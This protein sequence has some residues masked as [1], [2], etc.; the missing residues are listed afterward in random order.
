MSK[1]EPLDTVWPLVPLKEVT[2]DVPSESP[3]DNGKP[4][5]TYV[6]ISA[7]NNIRCEIDRPKRVVSAAAP[8]R[9]RRPIQDDDVLF[10]NVRTYLRNVAQVGGL[11]A[12]TFA[13]TGFT[14]LRP[15]PSIVSR[16]LYHVVRSD[17][18]IT[19]V[20]PQQTG[21]HYP[22]T[23][24]R[25]VRSQL[26]PLPD[27]DTQQR[28]ARVLDR[29]EQLRQSAARHVACGREA[30][31]RLR[32]AVLAAACSGQLTQ[33][34]RRENPGGERAEALIARIDQRRQDRLGN[35]YKPPTH[36]AGDRTLPNG[37]TWTTVAAVGDVATGATPLRAR[38]DYYG[39][40]VPWVT[41]SAVNAGLIMDARERITD[42]ALTETSAKVF[43]AGTLLVAMYGEGQT[44]G[45][46][47]ELGISAATNQAVAAI[48]FDEV[49]ESVQ[50]FLK[51]FLL[52]NYERIRQLSFGGVQ[53]NLSLG[54]IKSM[55]VAL[56]PADER[57]EIVRC[58]RACLNAATRLEQRLDDAEQRIDQ[59]S[60]ALLSSA[61]RGGLIDS[62]L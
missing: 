55:V 27:L 43:P 28:L 42:L 18:F 61:L 35:R 5:F 16:Y 9:A 29:T 13:S 45:R 1:S 36:P 51:V 8:S 2:I 30:S 3:A 37:W 14:V 59:T 52:A 39:G 62:S 23:S 33:N 20:T 60:Q 47:A 17:L 32:Q 15:G 44:R 56:P 54:V 34:W 31:E 40:A 24:D 25:V 49:S 50:P 19:R 58:V 26:I 48:L 7:I 53:P 12:P 21:T 57:E 4:E 6:D 38:S 11:G 10:S 22:A 41:S 46:V